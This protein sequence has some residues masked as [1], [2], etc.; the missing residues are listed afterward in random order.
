VADVSDTQQRSFPLPHILQPGE[1]IETQ[2]VAQDA[3]IAVT[4]QRLILTEA[5]RVVLDIPFS[6][7]RRI[8]LDVE[9]GRLATMVIVPEHISNEPR[10]VGV[11]V[12]QLKETA[13]TLAV[14]GERLNP[15]AAEDS[16]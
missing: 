11:P 16:A 7:L 6:A 9:R 13:L 1:V 12:R 15:A 8:Q 14:I 3:V 10:V 2:A 5:D 4:S